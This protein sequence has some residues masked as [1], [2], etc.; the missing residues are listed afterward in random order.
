ME[1]VSNYFN[2]LN[3]QHKDVKFIL[4]TTTD[5]DNLHFLDVRIKLNET[6]FDTCFWRKP[7]NIGL[8]LNFNTL[9]PNAW[10]SGFVMC[11]LHRAKKLC[12][13][14]K[15]YVQELKRLCHIFRN[16]AYPEWFIL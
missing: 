12:W 8:L 2:I 4:E 15:L 10:K 3:S 13:S 14:T 16:N 7:T 5:C 11:L 9:C 6:G 1:T